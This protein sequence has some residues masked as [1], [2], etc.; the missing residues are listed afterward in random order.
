MGCLWWRSCALLALRS[1]EVH[2]HLC[3][4]LHFRYCKVL[5]PRENET[6]RKVTW[7][8]QRKW[9]SSWLPCLLDWILED[10]LSSQAGSSLCQPLW[11]HHCPSSLSSLLWPL[12]PSDR[13][14]PS[15]LHK[16]RTPTSNVGLTCELVRN[17][18]SLSLFQAHWIEICHST[19]SQRF[20]CQIKF[21]KHWTYISWL[22]LRL[23][24]LFPPI[25]PYHRPIP[26]R[27]PPTHAAL[28]SPDIPSLGNLVLIPKT[29]S[30]PVGRLF[31]STPYF[32]L[33][34]SK[35]ICN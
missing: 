8:K 11:L 32:T 21:E 20:I 1:P 23:L 10:V 9:R 34:T 33:H 26:R 6:P 17:A 12:W 27:F 18:A 3:S 19:W 16:G 2:K 7:R 31:Y 30:L 25:S 28:Q 14:S 22:L 13:T 24:F 4:H 29:R 15:L 35:M 5:S